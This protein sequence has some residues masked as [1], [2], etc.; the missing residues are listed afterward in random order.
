M[1]GTI[2][3]RCESR[4]TVVALENTAYMTCHHCGW[5]GE[6]PDIDIGVPSDLSLPGHIVDVNKMVDPPTIIHGKRLRAYLEGRART[7]W[8]G[9]A[10]NTEACPQAFIDG[11]MAG[12]KDLAQSQRD[13]L[14]Q[15]AKEI[16]RE[17]K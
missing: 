4:D 8:A 7:V 2:C 15:A 12:W 3:P 13:G 10:G 16:A 5:K 1:S 6:N 14:S 17:L 9:M 11:L